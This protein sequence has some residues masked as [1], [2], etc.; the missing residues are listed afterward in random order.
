MD[1]Q[2]PHTHRWNFLMTKTAFEPIPSAEGLVYQHIEYAYLIC[3]GPHEDQQPI[4]A[5]IDIV[6]IDEVENLETKK[7]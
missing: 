4:V 3:N 2:R 6:K 1:Y 7:E 5:K